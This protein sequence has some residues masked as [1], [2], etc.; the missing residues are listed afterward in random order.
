VISFQLLANPF[1]SVVKNFQLM[2][3][4]DYVPSAT[5]TFADVDKAT[6]TNVTMTLPVIANTWINAGTHDLSRY[7]VEGKPLYIGFRYVNSFTAATPPVHLNYYWYVR[8]LVINNKLPNG[9]NK[10]M[11]SQATTVFDQVQEDLVNKGTI[12]VLADR[13]LLVGNSRAAAGTEHWMVSPKFEA[14]EPFQIGGDKPLP[15]KSQGG[16]K[17]LSFSQAYTKPGSYTAHFVVKQKNA[18]GIVKDILMP[19]NVTITE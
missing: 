14:N 16:S 19:V 15:I 6:W 17:L 5:P 3:S 18:E 1:P 9:S 8:S 2:V 13:F 11:G 4:T 7:V 12:T 10:L